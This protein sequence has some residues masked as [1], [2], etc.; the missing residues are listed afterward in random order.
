MV[1]DMQANTSII[2]RHFCQW[3]AKHLRSRGVS[4]SVPASAVF[5]K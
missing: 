4:A 3:L 1:R 2:P 5:G